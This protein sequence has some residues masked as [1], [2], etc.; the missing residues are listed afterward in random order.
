MSCESQSLTRYLQIPAL[1]LAADSRPY[2]D[3][4]FEIHIWRIKIQILIFLGGAVHPD[5]PG[6][7]K[8][9]S[10]EGSFFRFSGVFTA[11]SRSLMLSD[12]P[13]H[14][15]GLIV[16]PAV[17]PENTPAGLSI[18]H[19]RLTVGEI[20]A[21]PLATPHDPHSRVMYL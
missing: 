13:F 10:D 12:K 8:S 20:H 14:Q 11:Y 21:F 3:T 2:T 5:V 17:S 16:V 9:E 6:L 1:I 15:R 7:F 4:N 19:A 18:R